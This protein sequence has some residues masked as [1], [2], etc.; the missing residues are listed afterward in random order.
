MKLKYSLIL[1]TI[2]FISSTL[3]ARS[4]DELTSKAMSEDVATAVPAIRE[5]RAMGRTGLD[6]LFVKLSLIHI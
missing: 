1:M 6:A 5:L 4:V 2:L 3:R